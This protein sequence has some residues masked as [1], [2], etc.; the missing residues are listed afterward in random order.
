MPAGDVSAG[1]QVKF[2]QKGVADMIA[3]QEDKV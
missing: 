3:A 1:A 2:F